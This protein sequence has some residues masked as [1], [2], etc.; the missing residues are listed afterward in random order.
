MCGDEMP[1]S[2]PAA[3]RPLE[4]SKL[5]LICLLRHS[6]SPDCSW[7][8]A[9]G[10]CDTDSSTATAQPGCN[11]ESCT[12]MPRADVWRMQA[13][14][15]P[16]PIRLPGHLQLQGRPQTSPPTAAQDQLLPSASRHRQKAFTIVCKSPRTRKVQHQR[17]GIVN[18]NA[19]PVRPPQP[20]AIEH[21]ALPATQTAPQEHRRDGDLLPWCGAVPPTARRQTYHDSRGTTTMQSFDD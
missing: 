5:L 16:Q 17:R 10:L 9:L 4:A 6:A 7:P 14:H 8:Q 13:G 12:V 20:I 15:G 11:S 2:S 3:R 1:P 19:I 18:D 21:G